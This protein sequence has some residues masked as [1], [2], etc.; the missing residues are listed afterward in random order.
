MIWKNQLETIPKLKCLQIVHCQKLKSILQLEDSRIGD[1]HSLNLVPFES[2]ELRNCE[3]SF[4]N[5]R[6]L[7][8]ESCGIMKSLISDRTKEEVTEAHG[9][10]KFMFPKLISFE[11]KE[12]PQ[13]RTFFTTLYALEWPNLEHLCISQSSSE[14]PSEVRE[15]FS[16]SAYL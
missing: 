1:C 7:R 4:E 6:H 8:V 15:F 16:I 13:L 9:F 14:I 5:L 3:V 12:L 2:T 11:L 10:V